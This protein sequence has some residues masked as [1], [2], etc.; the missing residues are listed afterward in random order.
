MAP[1]A[2][3]KEIAGLGA[4]EIV[5]TSMDRDGTCDGYDLEITA[6]VSQAV[7]I[8]VVASG[9]AGCPEHLADAV[10]KGRADAALAASIFHFGQ[11]SIQET[12][13]IMAS[14]GIPVRLEAL[15][16]YDE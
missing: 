15:N 2:W 1:V 14:K 10:T 11:F 8:P 9:G 12:K 13:T 3:A 16:S 5:L 6:A 4:G 7:S